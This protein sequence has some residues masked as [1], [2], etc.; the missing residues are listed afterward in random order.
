LK[1]AKEYPLVALVGPRQSGKTTLARALF[2]HHK[3]LS[4]ENIDLRNR[5][6]EDPRGFLEYYGNRLILDKVQRT[7]DLFSYLQE[8]VDQN[9]TP[10]QYILTGSHQFL[11]FEGISQSLAGRIVTFKLFPFTH[12]ELKEYSEDHALSEVFRKLDL[13]RKKTPQKELYQLYPNN[14]K[15]WHFGGSKAPKFNDLK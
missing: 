5:A 9:P 1:Y 8:K 12:S 14:F 15:N 11:L 4:L 7:P 2:P 6:I 3:Y 13:T 10:G